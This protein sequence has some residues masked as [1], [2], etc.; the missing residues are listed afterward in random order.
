ME[1]VLVTGGTGLVGSAI[2]SI[3]QSRNYQFIFLSSKDCDLTNLEEIKSI[4]KKYNPS[5]VIHPEFR[6][7]FLF[8]QCIYI[9]LVSNV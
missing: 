2:K 9:N 7:V 3:H 4:F 8:S 6:I 5:Y 1:K